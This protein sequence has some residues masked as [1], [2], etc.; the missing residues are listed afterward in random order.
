MQ[1][2]C[3]I[4]LRGRCLRVMLWMQSMPEAYK[5][6]VV[7]EVCVDWSLNSLDY[8]RGG[9]RS[10]V[11]CPE[12]GGQ[13]WLYILVRE[14]SGTIRVLQGID[15]RCICAR[16][17]LFSLHNEPSWGFMPQPWVACFVSVCSN[18][19]T[20]TH[21]LLVCRIARPKTKLLWRRNIILVHVCVDVFE[22]NFL[23][24]LRHVW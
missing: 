7:K 9:L 12:R 8:F 22:N 19:I 15:W 3:T 17:C 21:L 16:K 10:L 5:E 6:V 4:V 24:Y 23:Q 14:G 2:N 20:Y 1:V 11:V 13:V 18:Y